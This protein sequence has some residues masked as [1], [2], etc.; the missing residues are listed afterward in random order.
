MTIP[1][2][3][4]PE[5]SASVYLRGR[6]GARKPAKVIADWQDYGLDIELQSFEPV[7]RRDLQRAHDPQFVADV[8]ACRADNGFGNRSPEVAASLRYTSGS[9]AA[10]CEHVLTCGDR[11]ACSPTSGFHHAG[12]AH[13][14]GF[15]TFNGLMVA[16]LQVRTSGL[17]PRRVGILDCD[18]HYGDGTQDIINWL[19]ISWIKHT[20]LGLEFG[21][22]ASPQLY[23]AAVAHAVENMANCDLV[24]YQAGADLHIDDPLGG[25]LTTAQMIE[26]DRIVFEGFAATPVRVVWNLAGGYRE[27]PDGSI[28]KV[29]ETHRNTMLACLRAYA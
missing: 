11:V 14:G 4:R 2:F 27:E 5:Q 7:G 26:R 20:S 12:Y 29:L 21:R 25:V 3:Y 17:A 24:I 13:A 16:A 15:C 19:G 1:V 6:P 8:L 9:I 23:L 10:A 18:F 22:G 28:P